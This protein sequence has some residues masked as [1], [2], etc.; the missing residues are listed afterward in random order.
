[1][2]RSLLCNVCFIGCRECFLLLP[3]KDELVA[4]DMYIIAAAEFDM[5]IGNAVKKNNR[6]AV[7]A[8]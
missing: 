2:A 4:G 3:R 6:P 8:R 7:A 1:M 5:A